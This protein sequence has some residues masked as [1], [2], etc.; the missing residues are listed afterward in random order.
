MF[1][2]FSKFHPTN[3]VNKV[4]LSSFQLKNLLKFVLAWLAREEK[5]ILT[6]Q[7]MFTYSHAKT[8]L[9]QSERALTILVVINVVISCAENSLNRLVFSFFVL[10]LELADYISFLEI[11]RWQAT[12]SS[13]A[14]FAVNFFNKNQV[15]KT[16]NLKPG[17]HVFFLILFLYKQFICKPHVT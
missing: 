7:V 4:N 12:G 1:V 16:L 11:Q 9:G 17:L 8:S 10:N 6:A 13:S 15:W 5:N 14:V 3:E 2:R